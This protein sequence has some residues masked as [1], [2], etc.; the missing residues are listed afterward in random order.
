[1]MSDI[2]QYFSEKRKRIIENKLRIN[3]A[4]V[5]FD[6]LNWQFSFIVENNRIENMDDLY[7]R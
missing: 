5:L 3:E 4:L 7:K 6:V 2:G 1:M